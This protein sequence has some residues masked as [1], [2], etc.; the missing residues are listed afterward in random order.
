MAPTPPG[1]PPDQA[2]TKQR[3]QRASRRPLIPQAGG[4]VRAGHRVKGASRH[5]STEAPIL[6]RSKGGDPALPC[7]E[8]GKLI[9]TAGARWR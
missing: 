4:L 3:V 5:P 2:G 1:L 7:R 9:Q 8:V 6:P